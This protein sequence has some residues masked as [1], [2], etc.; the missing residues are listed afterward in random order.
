MADENTRQAGYCLLLSI[1]NF[2]YDKASL[3]AVYYAQDEDG[4]WSEKELTCGPL[5]EYDITDDGDILYKY[6]RLSFVCDREKKLYSAHIENIRLIREEEERKRKEA[7]ER[8]RLEYEKRKAEEQKRQEEEER[9]RKEAIERERLEYEKR[10]AEEQKRQEEEA[11]S[12]ELKGFVMQEMARGFSL[13]ETRLVFEDFYKN[14][15]SY[16]DQQDHPIKDPDGNRLFKCKYCGKIS[17][18]GDFISHGGPGEINLGTCRE[19]NKNNKVLAKERS[20]RFSSINEKKDR[21]M[22]CP[23]CGGE[24]RIV[25]GKYGDFLGCGNYPK[26]RFT[27]QLR[28]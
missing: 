8:E 9:R 16:F 1:E 14:I 3:S 10:K 28:K 13:F 27:S 21:T 26:C 17:T 23:D 25:Q 20:E 12:E 24:L 18:D 15:D 22:T 6:E 2:E 7:K 5:S 11:I 19:C 4:L